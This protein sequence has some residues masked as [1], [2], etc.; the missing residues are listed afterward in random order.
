MYYFNNN[1]C[2]ILHLSPWTI[3]VIDN[4]PGLFFNLRYTNNIPID[5]YTGVVLPHTGKIVSVKCIVGPK[6]TGETCHV[7]ID[8][9]GK[10]PYYEG[11]SYGIIPP[12]MNPG[13]GKP[14]NARLYSIASTRWHYYIC[15]CSL[16]KRYEILDWGNEYHTY[17]STTNLRYGD[18]MMGQTASLCVRRTTYWDPDIGKEVIDR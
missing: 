11:Q 3:H 15:F 6:A 7:I 4:N 18:D 1:L 14:H 8:H 16:R 17:Y 5:T 12:G 9:Q 13:N 10:M 2:S